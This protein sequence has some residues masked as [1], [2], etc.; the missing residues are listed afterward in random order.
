MATNNQNSQLTYN[1]AATIDPTVAGYAANDPGF[2]LG[3]LLSRM[4]VNNYNER[5]EKKLAES[6]MGQMGQDGTSSSGAAAPSDGTNADA[7]I[8]NAVSQNLGQ[9]GINTG[10]GQTVPQ[11]FSANQMPSLSNTTGQYRIDPRLSNPTTSDAE[12]IAMANTIKQAQE[13]NAVSQAIAATDADEQKKKLMERVQA[14]L[15]D[16]NNAWAQSAKRGETYN[17]VGN[18][19]VIRNYDDPEKNL[20]YQQSLQ[21][22]ANKWTPHATLNANGTVSEPVAQGYMPQNA[23]SAI[24]TNLNNGNPYTFQVGNMGLNNGETPQSAQVLDAV[25]AAQDIK[26][27]ASAPSQSVPGSS[28][29]DT[30]KLGKTVNFNNAEQKENGEPVQQETKTAEQGESKTVAPTENFSKNGKT[31]QYA[32]NN[33]PFTV[34]D[35]ISRV[36]MEGLKQ[37]RPMQQIQ[38]VIAKTLP[39]AQA[40]EDRYK[41]NA[42]GNLTNRI[43]NGDET[44]GNNS[45][46]PTATNYQQTMP[47]LMST[48]QEIYNI[49]PSEG[50]RISNAIGVGYKDAWALNKNDYIKGRDLLLSK[51]LANNDTNN[52][53]RL[54]AANNESDLG[55]KIKWIQAQNQMEQAKIY[56]AAQWYMAAGDDEKT[57]IGKAIASSSKRSGG[58]SSSGNGGT[59]TDT[60]VTGQKGPHG[61]DIINGFEVSA[62]QQSRANELGAI[63]TRMRND[64]DGYTQT[65]SG[66]D[67]KNGGGADSLAKSIDALKKYMSELDDKDRELIPDSI[68]NDIQ[69]AMYAANYIREYKAGQG[70]SEIAKQY[71]SALTPDTLKTYHIE[72]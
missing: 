37:G 34:K 57:A 1:T 55:Q 38:A 71:L 50:E 7:N 60:A 17:R 48:L 61:R 11:V 10:E 33:T 28:Y 14:I 9:T 36:T 8:A 69:Q 65:V 72:V 12:K 49:D 66:D 29:W 23:L 47:K 59:T 40:Q 44:T 42:I 43:F 32:Q 56:Q 53:I 67:I 41:K 58:G 18:P 5:G 30:M 19:Y 22:M 51:D 35:W 31:V 46:L 24:Q 3:L 25:Q 13:Q 54:H 70:K 27:T 6:V 63:I 68:W 21:N 2:A 15:E 26:Q 45:L 52:K 39:M 62:S 64:M 20:A 4:W 16:P